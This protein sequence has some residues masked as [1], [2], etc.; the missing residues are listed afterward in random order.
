MFQSW[1]RYPRH[2]LEGQALKEALRRE[3]V[4]PVIARCDQVLAF[5]VVW[6]ETDETALDAAWDAVALQRRKCDAVVRAHPDTEFFVSSITGI[7]T[8]GAVKGFKPR[9]IFPAVSY[10]MVTTPGINEDMRAQVGI[11]HCFT[12][13]FMAYKSSPSDFEI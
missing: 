7:F 5:R 13:W 1:C 8:K 4:T 3:I 10:W 2:S 12:S 9:S 6:R 11:H